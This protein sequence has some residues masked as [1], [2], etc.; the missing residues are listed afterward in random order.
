[1]ER[2]Q[3]A[4]KATSDVQ[5]EMMRVVSD[6]AKQGSETQPLLADL[7]RMLVTAN[8]QSNSANNAIM[9]VVQASVWPF[10]SGAFGASRF[11]GPKG[12]T[13]VTEPVF[14]PEDHVSRK[15]EGEQ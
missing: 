9:E 5:Q 1:M 14:V 7:S 8:V 10:D 4:Q 2:F 12:T 13:T 3:T 6:L 11:P 15:P